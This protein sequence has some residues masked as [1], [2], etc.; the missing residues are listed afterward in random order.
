MKHFSAIWID[1]GFNGHELAELEALSAAVDARLADVGVA[2]SWQ[3]FA[4][5][6]AAIASITTDD[7]DYRLAILDYHF[8]SEKPLWQNALR[9]LRGHRIPYLILTRFRAD[10]TAAAANTEPDVNR[11]GIVEKG[12]GADGALTRELQL[13]FDAPPV[14]ILHVSDLHIDANAE[15]ARKDEQDERVRAMV[16]VIKRTSKATPIDIAALTGDF[17]ASEPA[18]DLIQ[19]VGAVGRLLDAAGI[20]ALERCCII[21]GNHDLHWKDYRS[22]KLGPLPWQ[23][24]LNFYSAVY[25][26]RPDLLNEMS[27]TASHSA[28]DRKNV[29]THELCWHRRLA[30]L[31][32]SILGIATPTMEPQHQ[33]Q[34]EF[35][36]EHSHFVRDQAVEGR[37]SERRL[38]LL[39][40]NLFA[41]L[42]LSRLDE[43]IVIHNSGDALNTLLSANVKAVLS[44]HTHVGNVISI[45]A[46]KLRNTAIEPLGRLCS[47]STGTSGQSTLGGGGLRAFNVIELAHSLSTGELRLEVRP[48]VYEQA[49]HRWV[50]L[51]SF[52]P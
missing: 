1:D 51:P 3:R 26:R 25:G 35:T 36:R 27:A 17:A 28:L 12:A 48:F 41:A 29:A 7:H 21:P 33:G 39:H 50:E 31:N 14:R 52:V 6:A 47:I 19:A 13:F 42:S 30:D 5:I 40:H 18:D 10:V 49:D 37:R 15:D 43:G 2:V 46:A 20:R 34:G 11:L 45:A 38:A 9:A 23:H 16:A 22:R 4:T 44:G 8:A 32:V 24:Y